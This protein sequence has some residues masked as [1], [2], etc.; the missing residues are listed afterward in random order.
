M[1]RYLDE[2]I[3]EA[4][5]IYAP[6]DA[7]P[8][9][10]CKELIHKFC[11]GKVQAK[12][13]EEILQGKPYRHK[14]RVYFVASDLMKY[15]D[16]NRF[17]YESE[18]WLW[19]IIRQELKGDNVQWSIKN[20]SKRLWHIPDPEPHREPEKSEPVEAEFQTEVF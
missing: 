17:K 9:G 10:R 8:T 16:T 14:N 5:I 18:H 19:M 4:D 6:E 11:L 12:N 20:A 15:L 1:G 2:K 7:S 3:Q 13:R